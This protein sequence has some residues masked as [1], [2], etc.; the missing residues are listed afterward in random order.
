M[1]TPKQATEQ[2]AVSA[3]AASPLYHYSVTAQAEPATLPRVIEPFAKLGLAPVALHAVTEGGRMS[4]DLR[5][6]GLED[7]MARHIA[8]RLRQMIGVEQVLLASAG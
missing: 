6:A 7:G 5:M 2:A 1:T 3:V 8:D 4:I